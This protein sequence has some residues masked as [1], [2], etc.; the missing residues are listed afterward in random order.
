M[1]MIRNCAI[2]LV[3][4]LAI[5]ASADG[6]MAA[7]PSKPKVSEPPHI[8]QFDTAAKAV[9]E[10]LPGCDFALLNGD[11]KSGPTQ[12]FFRLKAGT[13]FPRHWHSTPEN[14]VAIRG[15]LTFNFESGQKHTLVPGEHLRYQAGMIHWG[16]CE[17]DADCLFY[18]FND[19]PYDFNLAE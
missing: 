19:R 17:A 15:R 5:L 6:A 2:L 10:G 8:T 3:V 1:N 7:Q 16:Q 9:C 4:A 18:V 11:P 13:A 14:M 12:W